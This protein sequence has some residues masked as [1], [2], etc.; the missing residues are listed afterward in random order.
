MEASPGMAVYALSQGKG[1]KS[2]LAP[3]TGVTRGNSSR[4][5]LLGATA[6]ERCQQTCSA[7]V[8]SAGAG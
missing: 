1:H 4:E 8:C 6:L 2:S 3:D 5:V 7:Q